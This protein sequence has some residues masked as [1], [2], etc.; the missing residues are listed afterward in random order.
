M[1]HPDHG[2][3]TTTSRAVEDT[4]E[5]GET[6]DGGSWRAV[7]ESNTGDDPDDPQSSLF[8]AA[9]SQLLE[10]MMAA[11]LAGSL[12][13]SFGNAKRQSASSTRSN[14]KRRREA[15]E[16]ELRRYNTSAASISPPPIVSVEPNKLEKVHVK[17]DSD[18]EVA[19]RVVE[20]VELLPEAAEQD[21][22]DVDGQEEQEEDA[23]IVHDAE[24]ARSSP[25]AGI[26]QQEIPPSTMLRD[27]TMTLVVSVAC[28]M[29][30]WLTRM[31]HIA[32]FYRNQS[33]PQILETAEAFVLPIRRRYPA[34]P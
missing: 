21:L 9:Q 15:L 27:K 11:G 28:G 3:D 22:A 7:E 31:I 8:Q 5:C 12:P 24:E 29:L 34:R 18:G 17:Y 23:D 1:E 4:V 26:A 2:D 6:G 10:E 30:Q 33:D 19:E 20:E 13:M 16:Q 14:R 25:I 32:F